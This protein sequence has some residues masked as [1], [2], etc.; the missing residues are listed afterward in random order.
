MAD[1]CSVCGL[2]KELCMC[3]EIAR[4]QQSVRIY[5]DSRRYGKIVTVV[6]GIDATDIDIDDLARKLK[7]KCAAG[8][9]AKEGKI[10]LQGDHKKKVAQTLEEMGFKTEVR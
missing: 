1:I 2:P 5:T 3:E 9:T 7:N 4:E 6:D 10:E 8:G